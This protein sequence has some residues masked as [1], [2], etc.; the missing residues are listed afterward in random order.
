M[1]EKA[2]STREERPRQIDE[3]A[4][5]PQRNVD[6]VY[7]WVEGIHLGI[8]LEEDKLCLLVMVGVRADAA[9]SWL[10]SPMGS[11]SPL[12]WNAEDKARWCAV[13]APHLVALVRSG[14]R[15]ERGV[16]VERPEQAA[17]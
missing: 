15:F 1:P 8:R 17:A 3:K 12:I 9:K 10:P 14:A 4:A 11:A 2:S 16:L 7:L 5:D 6:Y 13:N